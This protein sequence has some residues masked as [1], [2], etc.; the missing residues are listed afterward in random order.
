DVG[1]P[2]Q[3]IEDEVRIELAA[4]QEIEARKGAGEEWG[5]GDAVRDG[6]SHGRRR[7]WKVERRA[8][9]RRQADLLA[10]QEEL[11]SVAQAVVERVSG[12]RS[13]NPDLYLR[14]LELAERL[15]D[16]P[17]VVRAGVNEERMGGSARRD[18]HS[19]ENR[20]FPPPSAAPAEIDVLLAAA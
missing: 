9:V 14:L 8:A 16:D 4:D 18:P 1:D 3:R 12:A 7:G 17:V 13:I 19:F 5:D 11:N 6:R 2:V 10:L 20:L 15:L